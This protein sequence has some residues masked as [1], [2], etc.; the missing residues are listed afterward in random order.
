METEDN[1][2]LWLSIGDLMS[3]VMF[4]FALMFVSVLAQLH[5]M[6]E[7][8][9]SRR[10]ALT[11][12]LMA[13]LEKN[14]LE[15]EAGVDGEIIFK[16]SMLFAQSSANLSESGEGL[17]AQF[18]PIYADVIFSNPDFDQ[19]IARIILEGHTS[20]EGSEF[21]NLSLS[22]RRAESVTLGLLSEDI[23]WRAADH[24]NQLRTRLYPAGRGEWDANTEVEATDRRV[25]LR[26]QFRGEHFIEALGG[27]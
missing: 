16:E 7:K 13:E 27:A 26:L 23:E 17:L 20:V 18:A 25:V 14:D 8:T 3:G 10:A 2:G 24:S 5:T 12:A 22:L 21:D 9:M 19:E 1:S 4:T 6:Q 15:V 11:A